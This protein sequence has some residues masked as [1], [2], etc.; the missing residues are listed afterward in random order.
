[1]S[2][3]L[4]WFP[5]ETVAWRGDL[6]LRTCS[7]AA[8]GVWVEMMLVMHEADPHGHFVLHGQPLDRDLGT[9]YEISGL[10]P[11]VVGRAIG[12]LEQKRVFSRTE[13]G[14]IYSRKMVRD[15]KRR[16]SD[17]SRQQNKRDRDRDVTPNV[18]TGVT[19]DVTNHVTDT[20][21]R[22]I[23]GE[24]LRVSDQDH[25]KPKNTAPNG[26]DCSQP[27][28]KSPEPHGRLSVFDRR[29]IAKSWFA[30]LPA[31]EQHE[32]LCAMV[33]AEFDAGHI[34]SDSGDDFEHLKK[35]AARAKYSPITGH[36][37]RKALD[38]VLAAHGLKVGA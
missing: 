35:V 38:G 24:S 33:S 9:F 5:F 15:R 14:V 34:V 3:R 12:E 27:V 36:Q 20:G 29:E 1:M 21:G 10:K 13:D 7:A 37:L 18:T 26:A 23:A 8:R 31:T 25:P 11:K 16:D 32:K 28:E 19:R 22:G 6:N 2:D 4:P 17:R 30:S